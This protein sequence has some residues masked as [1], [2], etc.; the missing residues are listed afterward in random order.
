MLRIWKLL[1]ARVMLKYYARSHCSHSLTLIRFPHQSKLDVAIECCSTRLFPRTL[2]WKTIAIL[3]NELGIEVHFLCAAFHGSNSAYVGLWAPSKELGSVL[4]RQNKWI[5]AHDRTTFA[6]VSWPLAGHR[7][8]YIVDGKA[9]VVNA[10]DIATL[11][12]GEV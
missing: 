7:L 8:M 5:A 6:V 10:G 4:W 1:F 3:S 9:C 12:M 2:A 11:R